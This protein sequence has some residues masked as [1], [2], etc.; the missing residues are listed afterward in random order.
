MNSCFATYMLCS[1][2]VGFFFKDL[3]ISERGRGQGKGRERLISGLPDEL[4]A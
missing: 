1:F 3:F 4:G 2:L